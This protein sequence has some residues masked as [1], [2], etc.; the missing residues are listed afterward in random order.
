MEQ[1]T[2]I[3]VKKLNQVTNKLLTSRAAR[4]WDSHFLQYH[5]PE[6]TLTIP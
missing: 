5:G 6:G 2:A 4:S 1:T 3:Y